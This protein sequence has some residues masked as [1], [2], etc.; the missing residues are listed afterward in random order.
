MKRGYR[1]VKVGLLKEWL[2]DHRLRCGDCDGE[3][4]TVA[5]E[6]KEALE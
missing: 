3:P 2:E 5:V 6:M 1:A 4:C